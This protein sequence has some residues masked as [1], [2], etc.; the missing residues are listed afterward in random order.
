MS[1]YSPSQKHR[2]FKNKN[3][4]IFDFD[5]VLADSFDTFYPL[6]R[7]GMK[8]IGL[9]FTEQHYRNFFVGN[10]HQGFKDFIKDERK[11]LIFKEF[12]SANYDGYYYDKKHGAKLFPGASNFIKKLSKK[13][14][15]A[16][17]SSGKKDN[18]ENLLKENGIVDLFGSILA[19]FSHSKEKMI[20]ELL[21][22]FR[23]KPE[24][25]V[26][27]T[28]TVGDIKVA[29]KCGLRTVAVTW[30]FHPRQLLLTAHPGYV[31]TDFSHLT[32]ILDS[33]EE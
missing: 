12:R 1:R 9:P 31:A 14:T 3:L 13:Y 19:D 11:Y 28:D 23:T 33:K 2:I 15:L 10:V 18:I 20:V 7:D 17:A 16:I 26:F 4:I 30:G 32:K 22:K 24:E 29:K 25:T 5:G 6:I 21:N 8:Q 27:I